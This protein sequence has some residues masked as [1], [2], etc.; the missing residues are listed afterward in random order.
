MI[1]LIVTI[2]MYKII[3]IDGLLLIVITP[4]ILVDDS[5]YCNNYGIFFVVIFKD[6]FYS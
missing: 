4:K 5:H 1:F 3:L 6:V 2:I